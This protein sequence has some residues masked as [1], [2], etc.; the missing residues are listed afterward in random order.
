[1]NAQDRE[2]IDRLTTAVETDTTYELNV[3]S[4]SSL[5]DYIDLGL[6]ALLVIAAFLIAVN[7]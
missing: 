1:M 5:L 4:A 6:K 2:A 3:E 7:V